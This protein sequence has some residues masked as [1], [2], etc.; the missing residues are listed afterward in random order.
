MPYLSCDEFCNNRLLFA[1]MNVKASSVLKI[2]KNIFKKWCSLLKVEL[3]PSTLV[4]SLENQFIIM[5]L[6]KSYRIRYRE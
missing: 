6:T 5:F 3:R 1:V 2:A 4:S